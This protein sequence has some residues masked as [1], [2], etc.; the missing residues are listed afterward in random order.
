MSNSA[1]WAS[2]KNSWFANLGDRW[3]GVSVSLVQMPC[4][5]GSPQG[6]LSAWI[7]GAGARADG[8]CADIGVTDAAMTALTAAAAMATVIVE[9]K[10]LSRMMVSFCPAVCYCNIP[11]RTQTLRMVAVF[12]IGR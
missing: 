9:L 7:E 4:K 5:S 3:N 1:R 2:V 6:V 8:A 11:Q 12:A 10:N